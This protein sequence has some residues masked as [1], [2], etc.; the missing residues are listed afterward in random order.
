MLG[1]SVLP[2][3]RV[4]TPSRSVHAWQVVL[5]AGVGNSVTIA[6]RELFFVISRAVHP[7][8]P[9]VDVNH[10]NVSDFAIKAFAAR[11]SFKVRSP[12]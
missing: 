8:E 10:P 6:M 2:S 9:L 11:L 7:V 1:N 5:V 3:C 12:T 4:T